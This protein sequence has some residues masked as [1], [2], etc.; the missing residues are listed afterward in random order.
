MTAVKSTCA[1]HAGRLKAQ[2]LGVVGNNRDVG[3]FIHPTLVVD[4]ESGFPLGKS[5]LQL[6]SRAL[7]HADKHQRN[8]QKLPPIAEGILQVV[9]IGRTKSTLLERRR[10]SNGDPHWRPR[11]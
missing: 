11:K 8:Y 1:S 3:F 2:G 10:R 9:G 5:R 6:W 7:D 4:G